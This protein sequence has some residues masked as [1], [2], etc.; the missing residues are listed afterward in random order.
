MSLSVVV[1]GEQAIDLFWAW[2]FSLARIELYVVGDVDWSAEVR[3]R[4]G[5]GKV[6]I[7]EARCFA[8]MSEF[9]RRMPGKRLD[10]VMLNGVASSLHSLSRL[11]NEV[12]PLFE[13]DGNNTKLVLNGSGA[14]NLQKF[15]REVVRDA[16]RP[17]N[18]FGFITDYD[19]RYV[20]DDESGTGFG[21]VSPVVYQYNNAG[22][23]PLSQSS[24]NALLLGSLDFDSK[25]YEYNG[26]TTHLMNT[27]QKL[28]AKLLP[29]DTVS[30]CNNSYREFQAMQWIYSI[31]KICLE[32]LLIILEETNPKNLG[33]QILSKPL[34]AGLIN[35]SLTVAKKM[36]IQLPEKFSSEVEIMKVWQT[37][38]DKPNVLPANVHYF[39]LGMNQF[40]DF[41]VILL[42]P[43]LLADEI[44]VRTPYL[45]FLYT[46]MRQYQDLN[47]GKSIW[48]RRSNV[49]PT[50]GLV[51]A[52]LQQ[53]KKELES[54]VKELSKNLVNQE[55]Q[56]KLLNERLYSEERR[57]QAELLELQ[58]RIEQ[59]QNEKKMGEM[60]IS[61]N[62]VDLVN[63]STSH[64]ISKSTSEHVLAGEEHNPTLLREKELELKKKELEL[65]EREL[66]MKKKTMYYEQQ[67]QQQQQQQQMPNMP[68][69]QQQQSSM[70]QPQQHHQAF[71]TNRKYRNGSASRL[72]E[73]I[74]AASM[75]D[76]RGFGS[77]TPTGNN[78]YYKQNRISSGQTVTSSASSIV[79]PMIGND[80]SGGA[81]PMPN[82]H[83]NFPVKPTSRKNRPVTMHSFGNVPG[84]HNDLTNG[85]MGNYSNAGS[86]SR[87]NSLSS[88][89]MPSPYMNG[90]AQRSTSNPFYHNSNQ[91]SGFSN[92]PVVNRIINGSNNNNS[93]S[94]MSNGFKGSGQ[95]GLDPRTYNGMPS[96]RSQPVNLNN[97]A[98]NNREPIRFGN[99]NPNNNNNVNTTSSNPQVLS[100]SN[101]PT[102]NNN[103]QAPMSQAGTVT[104]DSRPNSDR[105]ESYMNLSSSSTPQNQSSENEE[106]DSNKKKKKKGFSLF[107]RKKND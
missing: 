49:T 39:N 51:E 97:M 90:P 98:S 88:S 62:S 54:K 14:I 34:I 43:I 30:Y 20:S 32:P 2:R 50:N 81:Y 71:P 66:S 23:V 79:N 17:Q 70:Q 56:M 11:V 7:D 42:Q 61:R 13:V 22:N 8:S 31:P 19:M 21:G 52:E 75:T 25:T 80:P 74:P 12:L 1:V 89:T 86:Q 15:V 16:I 46:V 93:A 59:L 69:Q 102:Y 6:M 95:Q 29:G 91:P 44:G 67:Q 60:S 18:I 3:S 82:S 28:F 57:H 4:H 101:Y 5:T 10:L 63:N 45:E 73:Y 106:V 48:F 41:D 107:K 92:P 38:Y 84:Y 27:F 40:I 76:S 77:S 94:S 72:N 99:T 47:S 105:S 53:A 26:E 100:S 36:N 96:S 83:G 104:S 35:E 58:N 9:M 68:Q 24:A 65:Q 55:N 78:M 33:T 64:P 37:L 85:R 103:L 87:F